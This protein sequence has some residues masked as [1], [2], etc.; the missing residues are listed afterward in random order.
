MVNYFFT[1]DKK[2]LK[3]FREEWE[4]GKFIRQSEATESIS[5][6]WSN[7]KSSKANYDGVDQLTWDDL[8]M[9]KV[10][11]KLNY[12]QTTVGSEYL[13][14][15]LREI[16]PSLD[17]VQEDENLYTLVANNQGLRGKILLLLSGLGKRDYMN[18]TSFFYE[19]S[20]KKI[21]Y[22]SVYYLLAF[23]PVASII[24]LFLNLKWGLF[25]LLASFLINTIIYYRNKSLLEYDLLSTTYIASI[26]KTGK[27]FSSVNHSE[28]DSYEKRFRENMKPLK[29]I[30][31]LSN[32][33]SLGN[34]GG[35]EFDVIFEYIRILFLLDFISFNKIVKTI[36]Q[37]QKQYR[38]VWELIGKLDA[39]IAVAFY[40]KSI[41][42]YCTPVFVDKEE[43]IFESMAHPL[44]DNPV[45]NTSTLGKCTLVT[46]SNA[47]G[48]ST[49]IKAI[50]INAIL[51][52]TINTVLAEKWMMKPSYVATSMAIQDNVL[53]GDSYFIAEIKSLKRIVKL[54]EDGKPC[55]SFIDEILKG[56][57]TIERIASSVAMMEWLSLNKGMSIIASHDIELT[58]IASH[59]YTNYHFRESIEN[60]E[61]RFDYTIHAGPSNT[62]NAIKLLE[63]L[64]YPQ[65]ITEKANGLARNFTE[66][67][68][69]DEMV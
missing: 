25:C 27:H 9:D 34:Q 41:D 5:S 19:T 16:N 32:I 7:K 24:L 42:T 11:Q 31:L 13:F 61:V 23:L 45:T 64:G 37:N 36:S 3:K 26:I 56:T 47:S 8:S 60:G 21:K 15:Q 10:F 20:S 51:A 29:K 35:G 63:V 12:T 50:A 67:R 62:R 18:S 22:A 43:L 57:N 65:S 14:N 66:R 40:R 53:D 6:Y 38:E 68:E 58:E 44:I 69:W 55:L 1:K 59:V 2:K 28:F 33:S 39:A 17:H 52:Q 49:Y 30:L 48:K 46:G 4:T 54:I